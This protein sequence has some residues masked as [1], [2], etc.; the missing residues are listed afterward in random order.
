MNVVDIIETLQ[1]LA[2][3]ENEFSPEF[4]NQFS[5]CIIVK[6]VLFARIFKSFFDTEVIDKLFE[7][8]TFNSKV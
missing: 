3:N 5:N 6:F 4:L 8:H 2:L 7:Y 1:S